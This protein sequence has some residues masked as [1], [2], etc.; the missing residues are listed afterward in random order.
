MEKPDVPTFPDLFKAIGDFL[1]NAEV[2][3]RQRDAWKRACRAYNVLAYTI[4]YCDKA[5]PEA[6]LKA[7]SNIEAETQLYPCSRRAYIPIM[8]VDLAFRCNLKPYVPT[9]LADLARPCIGNKPLVPPSFASR[10]KK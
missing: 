9:L 10:A 1:G 4:F 5:K 8:P 3:P 7:I 6:K 2:D